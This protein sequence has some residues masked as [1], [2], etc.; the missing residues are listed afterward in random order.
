VTAFKRWLEV[1]A[2]KTPQF[3]A[4]PVSDQKSPARRYQA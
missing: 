4:G 3:G 1:E 2:E